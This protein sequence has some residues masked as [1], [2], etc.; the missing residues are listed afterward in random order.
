MNFLRLDILKQVL[1]SYTPKLSANQNVASSKK[2]NKEFKLAKESIGHC[3]N[4][5]DLFGRFYEIFLASHPAIEEKFENT[6]MQKQKNLLKNGVNLAIMFAEGNPI[7]ENAMARL[8]VSHNKHNL[9]IHPRF[10]SYWL[11]SFI[12]AMSE[13]DDQ[14][15]EET[16]RQVRK[17][18]LISIDYI[19]AGYDPQPEK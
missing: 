4:I 1:K 18:L 13:L 9:N 2:M 16:E 11:D 14:F 10:Y 15:N 6:D 3:I 8:R 7:G 19:I 12:K 5:G 17:L